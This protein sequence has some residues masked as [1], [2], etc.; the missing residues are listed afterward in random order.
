MTVRVIMTVFAVQDLASSKKFYQDVFG[1]SI[2]LEVPVLVSFKMS[3]NHELMLYDK[4]SFARNTGQMPVLV[5]ENCIS[6][7]ELYFHVDDLE[8]IIKKLEKAGAR[9]LSELAPRDWGDDVAYYADL[10]GNVL[11]VACPIQN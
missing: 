1:W 11:A 4:D 2:N 10:D 6:S 9:M 5:P 8:G 3:N 7:T